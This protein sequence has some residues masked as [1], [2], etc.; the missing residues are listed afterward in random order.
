MAADFTRLTEID[1]A[2]VYGLERLGGVARERD[3]ATAAGSAGESGRH[4]DHAHFAKNLRALAEEKGIMVKV[5]VGWPQW[6]FTD[7]A[8]G[9]LG[10]LGRAPRPQ[11]EGLF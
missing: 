1:R 2:L 6:C 3:L 4:G 10:H 9:K 11:Q 8:W 7:E 5:V